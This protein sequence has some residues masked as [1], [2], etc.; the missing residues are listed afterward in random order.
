M[1]DEVSELRA[2]RLLA[3]YMAAWNRHDVAKL[4]SLFAEDGCYGEFGQGA[5]LFGREDI[6]RYL[7]A[8]FPT[9]PK[10]TTTLT[11]YPIC[12]GGRVLCRCVMTATPREEFAGVPPTGKSFRVPGTTVLIMEGDKI[13][14]AA[15]YYDLRAVAR[16]L[17]YGLSSAS[18]GGQ[19]WPSL[20]ATDVISSP[21]FP[22][23]EDNI[24]YGE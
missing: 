14:R 2:H 21:D 22:V 16:Q 4:V 9:L 15:D 23:S 6:R 8:K 24:R 12:D 5:V 20:A 7:S 1:K 13:V 19:L 18:E 10:L 17:R 11:A 3:D